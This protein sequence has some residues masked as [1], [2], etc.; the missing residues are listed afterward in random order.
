MLR[1]DIASHYAYKKELRAMIIEEEKNQHIQ[2]NHLDKLA[3]A[4]KAHGDKTTA[5]NLNNHG[6]ISYLMVPKDPT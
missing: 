4:Y 5:E 1:E 2:K 6:G 3:D